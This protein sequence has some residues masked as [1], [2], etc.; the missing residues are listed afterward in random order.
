M[1]IYRFPDQDLGIT[2]AVGGQLVNN[3]LTPKAPKASNY[4]DRATPVAIPWTLRD[5]PI[6]TIH[7]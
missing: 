3:A 5:V 1:E 2:R 4:V 7:I 6:A